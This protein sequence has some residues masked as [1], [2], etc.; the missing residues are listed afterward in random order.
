MTGTRMLWNAL[1]VEKNRITGKAGLDSRTGDR[2][3]PEGKSV[4]E[5][6]K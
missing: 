3:N 4:W 6:V 1:S 2:L 5:S